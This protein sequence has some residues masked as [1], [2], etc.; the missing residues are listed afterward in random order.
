M[1]SWG[2]LLFVGAFYTVPHY[3][4]VMMFTDHPIRFA[5]TPDD[6]RLASGESGKVFGLWVMV[7]RERSPFGAPSTW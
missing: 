1:R 3:G 5:A 6:G 4:S 7:A 2:S